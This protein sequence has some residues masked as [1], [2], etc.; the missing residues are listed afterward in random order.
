MELTQKQ[1][2][3]IAITREEI[4]KNTVRK[5]RRPFVT[6]PDLNF[7][8]E[9]VKEIYNLCHK[10]L[11]SFKFF[12]D[13]MLQEVVTY[14]CTRSIYMYNPEISSPSNF[15]CR[16]A[17][18][19]T[20][21]IFAIKNR[22]LK[23]ESLDYLKCENASQ[24]EVIEDE[25]YPSKEKVEYLNFLHKSLKKYPILNELYIND[26]KSKQLAEEINKTRQSI[27]QKRDRELTSLRKDIANA[28]YDHN[29][30]QM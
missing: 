10:A 25:N 3:L 22:V 1:L 14:V 17:K 12:D 11:Q 8:N 9:Q 4:I 26:K 15:I 19:R 18:N 7:T 13:D 24:L 28:G 6:Y 16:C 27:E 5:N 2:E 23:C 29:P 30:L 21:Q 20:M